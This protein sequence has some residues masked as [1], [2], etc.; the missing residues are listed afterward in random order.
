MYSDL[1]SYLGPEP[2]SSS[3]ALRWFGIRDCARRNP[4]YSANVRNAVC[5]G[6]TMAVYREINEIDVAIRSD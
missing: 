2:D 4:Q 6:E 5:R 1:R 3:V